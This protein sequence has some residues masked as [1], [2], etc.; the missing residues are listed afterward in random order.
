MTPRNLRGGVSAAHV[1]QASGGSTLLITPV[2]RTDFGA[3]ATSDADIV[4]KIDLLRT[5]S[6]G[7][8][9]A[10]VIG[11]RPVRFQGLAGH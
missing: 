5:N 8:M 11:C 6:P 10:S 1:D 9:S 3:Q 4:R 2:P 7:D